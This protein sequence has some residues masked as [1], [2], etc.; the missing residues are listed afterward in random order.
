M[1]NLVSRA[2]E[3]LAHTRATPR[4]WASTKESYLNRVQAIVQ[5]AV[6]SK[7]FNLRDFFARHVGTRGPVYIGTADP[8]DDAW[9]HQVVD[10]ALT[11]IN[12]NSGKKKR[13]S[14]KKKKKVQPA[15]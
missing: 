13:N 15:V 2:R 3:L 7:D 4:M 6:P 10:E 1:K 11:I 8:V 9:A 14:G 5:M 12:R